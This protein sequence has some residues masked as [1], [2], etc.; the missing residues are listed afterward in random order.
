MSSQKWL[1]SCHLNC[2]SKKLPLIGPG[3]S[4]RDKKCNFSQHSGIAL[5]ACMCT[6]HARTQNFTCTILACRLAG[7]RLVI[8]ALLSQWRWMERQPIS[9]INKKNETVYLLK[10]FS[11]K[12][13]HKTQKV[14][15]DTNIAHIDIV[16]TIFLQNIVPRLRPKLCLK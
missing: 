12:W 6:I 4:D 5:R 16:M 7:G 1:T 9:G 15:C 2:Q 11:Q 8:I 3:L 14:F 10:Y 13:L